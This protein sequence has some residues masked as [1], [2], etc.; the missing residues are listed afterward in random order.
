MALIAYARV[1]TEDQTTDPQI[2][3]LKAAGAKVIFTENASGADRARPELR[4]AIERCGKGDVLVVVRIDRLARSLSHLLEVIETLDKKG[5][6]F[7]SLSDPIDTT[8]PQGRFTLQILGAVAEF[9]RALIHERTKAGIKA[10]VAKGKKP[11]N[12]GLRAGDPAAWEKTFDRREAQRD[13][14]A[15]AQTSPIL[16]IVKRLRPRYPWDVVLTQIKNAGHKREG[17]KP[18]T[19]DA[20]IRSCKRMVLNGL[21]DKS[22]MDAAPKRTD[23]DDLIDFIVYLANEAL[24]KPTLAAIGKELEKAHKRT[25]NGGHRWAASSVKHLLDKAKERGLIKEREEA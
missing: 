20:L 4:K 23:N 9:E 15:I 5:A 3:A 2:A 6:G 16:G 10:A 8:S 7:R 22:V 25:P 14:R 17:D 12:P 1:S 21:L 18:W 24:E 13:E 11:G 19:R